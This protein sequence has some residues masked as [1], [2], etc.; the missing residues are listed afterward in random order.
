M[1]LRPWLR[2]AWEN[3]HSNDGREVRASLVTMGGSF[4]LPA[5]KVD[6]TYGKVD[7]GVAA[8]FNPLLSAFINYS[9]TFSQANQKTNAVMVGLKLAM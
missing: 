1:R 9:T 6:D 3:E 8:A 2:V 7:V 5:Y 4:S